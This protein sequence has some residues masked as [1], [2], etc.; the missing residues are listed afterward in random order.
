MASSR[1]RRRDVGLWRS[2]D[3][4]EASGCKRLAKWEATRKARRYRIKN[5][6]GA[7]SLTHYDVVHQLPVTR[8]NLR[9]VRSEGS[10]DCASADYHDTGIQFR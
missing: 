9:A 2:S 7:R 5:V 4:A 8:D 10:A 3:L 1:S 6:N